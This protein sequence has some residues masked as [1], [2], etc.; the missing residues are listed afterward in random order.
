MNKTDQQKNNKYINYWTKSGNLSKEANK[1]IKLEIVTKYTDKNGVERTR[2]TYRHPNLKDLTFETGPTVK[3][4]LTKEQKIERFEKANFSDYHNKLVAHAYGTPKNIA[5]QQARIAA[6]ESKITNILAEMQAR[7]FAKT[8]E[9][10]MNKNNLLI[11]YRTN[12]E[13]TP[14]AF[15]ITPSAKSLDALYK[16]AKE[17]L[18][19]L[20]KNMNNFFS[21]QIWERAEYLKY[22][23][24]ETANYRYCIYA[25]NKKLAA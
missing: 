25:K 21:I 18:P 8:Q 10:N 7:K 6:H 17:M 1:S 23:A 9:R 16:D 13:G 11:I 19:F 3:K 24:H 20:E 2:T 15:S 5:K 14:Y 12:S 22:M 4:G